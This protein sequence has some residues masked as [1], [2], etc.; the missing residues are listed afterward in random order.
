MLK[1][2]LFLALALSALAVLAAL[3]LN[4]KCCST[5]KQEDIESNQEKVD[6]PVIL[7]VEED[8]GLVEMMSLQG[9]GRVQL[10][11]RGVRRQLEAKQNST[12]S[13]AATSLLKFTETPPTVCLANIP[14]KA[15]F[16]S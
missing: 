13:I 6:Q 2:Y 1:E 10:G 16:N 8:E 11:Q 15:R 4:E 7:Q 14:I 12:L 9:R 5:K 3:K